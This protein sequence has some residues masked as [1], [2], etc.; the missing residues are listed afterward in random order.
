MDAKDRK[1]ER[2]ERIVAEQ[3][4]VIEKLTQRVEQLE[5]E[6]AAAKKNSS[7]SSKPP[8]RK[9][10]RVISSRSR[11]AKAA[12]GENANENRADKKATRSTSEHRSRPTKSTTHGTTPSALV[13]TAAEN[14][15]PATKRRRLFSKSNSSRNRSASTNTE[16]L[17]IGVRRA[18]R[19]TTLHSRPRWKKANCSALD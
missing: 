12:A 6:L 18:R 4:A 15:M 5:R 10:R 16:G 3:A 1:I 14:S 17:R 9:H 8:C 11:K 2:L 19:F 13:P 7:N